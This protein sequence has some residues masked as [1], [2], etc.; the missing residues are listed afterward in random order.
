MKKVRKSLAL[1]IID[2]KELRPARRQH[3]KPPAKHSRKVKAMTG[4][5]NLVPQSEDSV[6]TE[7]FLVSQ[8]DRSLSSSFNSS[9]TVKKE[10]NVL[11]QGFILGPN[12]SGPTAKQ[13]QPNPNPVPPAPVSRPGTPSLHWIYL[14]ED[15]H[16]MENL[17]T[18][19]NV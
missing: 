15:F 5:L 4:C 7:L 19:I 9:Y 14:F 8:A 3:S 17:V 10:E 12:E 2:C 11:D 13:A 1:D 16:V 6:K 18:V